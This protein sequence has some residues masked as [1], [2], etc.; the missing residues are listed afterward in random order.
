MADVH[1]KNIEKLEGPYPCFR[2]GE[3]IIAMLARWPQTAL[4]GTEAEGDN[5]GDKSDV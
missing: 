1:T 4:E 5:S 3:L 2:R